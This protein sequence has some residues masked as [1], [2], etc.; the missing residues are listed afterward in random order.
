MLRPTLRHGAA[1]P[2]CN[3]TLLYVR[4][5][6]ESRQL[7]RQRET[8]GN[9]HRYRRLTCLGFQGFPARQDPRALPL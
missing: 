8:D 6:R 3:G 1:Q 7:I 5:R 4:W 2:T 9:A